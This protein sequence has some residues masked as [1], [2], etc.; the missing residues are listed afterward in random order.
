[1]TEKYMCHCYIPSVN[2]QVS[3]FPIAMVAVN[4]TFIFRWGKIAKL[5][6]DSCT[7]TFSAIYFS[8]MKE[9]D[10]SCLEIVVS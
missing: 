5:E 10:G 9:S 6:V 2:S 1:M 3:C 4:I 8:F 7:L